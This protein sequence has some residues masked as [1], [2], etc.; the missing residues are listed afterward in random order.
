MWNKLIAMCFGIVGSVLFH[1]SKCM[2]QHGI[3]IIRRL[4]RK[5]TASEILHVKK[6]TLIYSLGVFL[7]NTIGV[8][9]IL[10]NR[11][12]P[13]SYYTS[14]FG[15]GLITLMFYSARILHEEIDKEEYFG[16]ALVVIGTL[17]L[18][19]DGI[20]RPELNMALIDLK[21]VVYITIT[22][23][24]I[25]S[26]L[27]F[28]VFDKRSPLQTG[29]GFG[30]ITGGCA[31]LDPIYKSIGQTF[32]GTPGFLPDT[33]IG[34]VFFIVSFVF[35]TGAFFMTQ[36]AFAKSARAAVLVSVQNCV[37]VIFPIFIQAVAL[38]G[39]RFRIFTILG[40]ISVSAGIFFMQFY[41]RKEYYETSCSIS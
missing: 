35:T 5:K 17:T 40:L 19:I 21:P 33:S 1:I 41:K 10:A 22:F 2:Q 14:M 27:I 12:A 7:N 18:G 24:L 32:G 15:F 25:T 28:C 29:I 4:F 31:S 23:F 9:I 30:I 37:Y 16:S 34:T 36:Y 8:L 13:A 11:Y 3:D 6:K 20:F 39:F 38:P 26:F